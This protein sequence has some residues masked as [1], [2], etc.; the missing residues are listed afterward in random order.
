MLV[1]NELWGAVILQHCSTSYFWHEEETALLATAASLISSRMDLQRSEEALIAAKETADS[2]NRAK[3]TFL[4]TM[5]HEIRTPL[6]AVI[7]MSS[8]ILETKLDS[9]QRDYAATITTSAE[10]LLDLINDILDYSKIEAGRIEIENA[11]FDLS[12]VIVEPLEILARAAAEKKIEMSY[13]LDPR[14]PPFVVGDRTRVKQVLLNLLSNAVKFTEAGEISIVVEP[15]EKHPASIRFRVKDS[16]IGM[17]EEVQKNLF[18]PFMQADSSVTRRFG[19]TGLGLAISRRLIEL[20]K[21]SI[22]VESAPGRGTTFFFS[23]PLS[24]GD[25]PLESKPSSTVSL[26]GLRALIVDDNATNRRFL[27]Y[28]IALWGMESEEVDSGDRALEALKS[29]ARFQILLLDY[30]MPGMDGIG[31]AREIRK[32][33]AAANLP[34]VLLSSIVEKAPHGAEDLFAAVLTKPLRPALLQEVISSALAPADKP[35]EPRELRTETPNALKVLVAE[36]NPTNQKVIR[37]ML[38]RLG[39]NPTIVPNGLLAL[40]SVKREP[41]DLVLMDVQMSVMDGLAAARAMRAHF[42]SNSRPEI[43]ALTANAFKE[44]REACLAAGMDG[45]LVKPIT[46]ERLKAIIERV[47]RPSGPAV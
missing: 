41:F 27:R 22:H 10:T 8:L 2:A 14:I 5:S 34:I 45:Y 4:A 35:A 21:G 12:E 38:T 36:D 32:L 31:L 26:V 13:S 47:G 39:A 17:S 20:M 18:Q 42:G 25:S 33:P 44:D 1:E 43:I 16:G 29:P 6:N 9:L 19:G 30:Q 11:P 23:I 15:D 3:S 46:M 37:L 28:Q 7:G 24:E 40:E